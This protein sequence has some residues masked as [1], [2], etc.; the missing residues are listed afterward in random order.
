MLFHFLDFLFKKSS[1]SLTC[2]RSYLIGN[3]ILP[4]T[5][6]NMADD[7]YRLVDSSYVGITW[8]NKMIIYPRRSVTCQLMQMPQNLLQEIMQIE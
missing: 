8:I 2:I 4:L 7:V 5:A 6:L 3:D 1:L